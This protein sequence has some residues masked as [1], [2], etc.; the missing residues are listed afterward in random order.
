MYGLF[1][2]QDGKWVRIYESL[3]GP[4][5]W[6]VRIF[7]NALLASALGDTNERQLRVV[8]EEK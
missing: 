3:E 8:K 2:K 5:D 1:E 4:K 6:A 7:Q